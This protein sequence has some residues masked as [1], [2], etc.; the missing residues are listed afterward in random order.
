METG[1]VKSVVLYASNAKVG[2]SSFNFL[3]STRA[4][5]CARLA[6]FQPLSAN[7]DNPMTF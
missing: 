7:E 1:I 2:G 6:S 5:P 4:L 3:V